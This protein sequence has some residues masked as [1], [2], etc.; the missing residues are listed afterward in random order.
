MRRCL[1]SERGCVAAGPSVEWTR[2]AATRFDGTTLGMWL[3]GEAAGGN[4]DFTAMVSGQSM[5]GGGRTGTWWATRG[6]DDALS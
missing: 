5:P 2:L 3:S 4:A 6:V 1:D